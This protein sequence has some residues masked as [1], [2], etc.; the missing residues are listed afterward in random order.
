[1]WIR[2]N[3]IAVFSLIAQYFDE[4]FKDSGRYCFGLQDTLK[5]LEIGAIEI[6]IIW[7]NFD[8]MRYVLRNSQTGEMK[9]IYL[10]TDEEKEKSHFQDKDTGVELIQVE[11][12]RLVDWFANNY[13]EVG[14]IGVKLEIV[15]D[16]SQQ[17]SQF[18]HGFTGIG[19]SLLFDIPFFFNCYFSV[20]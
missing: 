13:K 18:V 9:I 17:G 20:F 2:L 7:E 8:L 5:E 4:I 16:K 3:F 10:R 11:K 6:L 15:T 1:L 12:I 19:G 14:K